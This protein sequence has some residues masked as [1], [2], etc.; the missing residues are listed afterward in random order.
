MIT[1]TKAQL[2]GTLAATKRLEEKLDI[3]QLV[4]LKSNNVLE[5]RKQLGDITYE[6]A[7]TG[8]AI[9]KQQ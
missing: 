3:Q 2:A 5:K 8:S 4:Q 1:T 9:I 7:S 6:L